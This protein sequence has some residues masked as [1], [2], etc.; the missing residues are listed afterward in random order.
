MASVELDRA[1]AVAFA[2]FEHRDVETPRGRIHLA[3]GG[4]GPPI[5]LLHGYP[6]THLMW[7]GV[8]PLLTDRHTVVAADLAGYGGSFLPAPT[9]DHAP[10][11]KRALALDQVQAMVELG[12]D[13]F[14]VV[15]HDRGGRVAYRM[16]LDHPDVVDAARGAGHRPHRR[17]LAASGPGLRARL[18]ALVLPR[19]AVAPAGAPDR[20]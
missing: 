4:S 1:S 11:G 14:A 7:R 17:G 15:G 10:H 9:A 6:Q 16:A 3:V 2:G 20:R 18:L 13:R 12:F 19:I 8:A 5:L